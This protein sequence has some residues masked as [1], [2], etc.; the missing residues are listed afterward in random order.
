V[1]ETLHSVPDGGLRRVF[2]L[3]GAARRLTVVPGETMAVRVTSSAG[4]IAAGRLELTA[5]QAR[6]FE[7]SYL[8]APSPALNR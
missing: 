8:P 6:R 7:L 3:P 2:E 4:T 1:R 5:E